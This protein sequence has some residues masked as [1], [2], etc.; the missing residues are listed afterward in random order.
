LAIDAG[1]LPAELDPRH[2]LQAGAEVIENG[3]S[4]L[5][6]RLTHQMSIP[7]AYWSAECCAVVAFM[8]FRRDYD[9]GQVWAA[10]CTVP[11]AR[12]DGQWV[13]PR[14][15]VFYWQSYAFDPVT[16]PG[17]DRHLDGNAMTYGAVGENAG[18]EPGQPASVT[19]G[20]V[21]PAVRYLAVIQDG[22][23][24]YRPLQSH[25]GAWVVCLE[26]PGIFDVAAFDSD[27]SLLACLEH[28]FPFTRHLRRRPSK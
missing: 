21:S 4:E 24:D 22:R 7:I 8:Q 23:Q 3:L 18:H 12:E 16:D 17:C 27:G 26:Q 13:P 2:W 28:P 6:S 1:E 5:P 9:T 10:T 19:L 11:Y 14:H 15:S 20:H 25:F